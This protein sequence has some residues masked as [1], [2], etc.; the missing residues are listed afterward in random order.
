[1]VLQ[2]KLRSHWDVKDI[3]YIA[4]MFCYLFFFKFYRVPIFDSLPILSYF[5]SAIIVGIVLFLLLPFVKGFF[6]NFCN[7]VSCKKVSAVLLSCFA[8]LCY[9]FILPVLKGSLDFSTVETLGHLFIFVCVGILIF[10][11]LKTKRRTNKL[12]EYIILCFVIQ[13]IIQYIGFLIPAFGN[14]TNIFKSEDAIELKKQ[15]DGFRL[16]AISGSLAFGLATG[17]SVVTIIFVSRWNE[18]RHFKPI[19]K[20]ILFFVLIMGGVITGRTALLLDI[21]GIFLIFIRKI[22]VRTNKKIARENLKAFFKVGIVFAAI[23]AIGIALLY[24]RPEFQAAFKTITVWLEKGPKQYLGIGG[25]DTEYDFFATNYSVISDIKDIFFGDGIWENSDGTY[26]LHQDAGYVRIFGF[27]GL[28]W[29]VILIIFQLNF[30]NFNIKKKI[31]YE[32]IVLL[33]IILVATIKGD[34]IGISLNNNVVIFMVMLRD[35]DLKG[36]KYAKSNRKQITG[37]VRTSDGLQSFKCK[38]YN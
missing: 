31:S 17:Y 37:N 24:R 1:M 33:V 28:V 14:F 7:V 19:I 22:F 26:Y 36:E 23:L 3:A 32:N 13:T 25:N 16:N 34:N 21:I 29:L 38:K 10:S 30:F 18:L 2:T 5:D 6:N 8:I 12:T 9:A 27:G 20:P 4:M 35:L 11:F 15:Y